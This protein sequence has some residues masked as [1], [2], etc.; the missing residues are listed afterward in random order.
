MKR[1]LLNLL[2]LL[3]LLLRVA[4]AVWAQSYL[5]T[6]GVYLRTGRRYF[7]LAWF[8]GSFY[9]YDVN[10][11]DSAGL[12]ARWGRRLGLGGIW[13]AGAPDQPGL[14]YEVQ[15]IDPSG[16]GFASYRD[17]VA[18]RQVMSFNFVRVRCWVVAAAVAMPTGFG[19]CAW[20]LR[21]R[22][23]DRH[24]HRCG[25]DLTGNVSGVCPECG[26]GR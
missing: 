9:V 25:Y 16:G 12:Q 15:R 2:T 21:R 13:D 26:N 5:G 4:A 24:C 18:P 11:A 10:G 22:R 19:W 7:E 23:R 1:R 20:N 14:V 3:S 6:A 17:S 8:D